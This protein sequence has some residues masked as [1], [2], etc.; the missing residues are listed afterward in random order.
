MD[1]KLINLKGAKIANNPS[2]QIPKTLQVSSPT[3]LSLFS[4]NILIVM[5]GI[6][7]FSPA[8]RDR[9]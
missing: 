3:K 5:N 4:C 8:S 9:D 7:I 2:S 1:L 6:E